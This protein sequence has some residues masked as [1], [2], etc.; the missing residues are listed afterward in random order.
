M[1]LLS[2]GERAPLQ[3]LILVLDTNI[4]LSH[5]DYVKKMRSHSLGGV[6]N[7][8]TTQCF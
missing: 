4:L 2:T 5:L 6:Y 1:N 3:D 7:D 8:F